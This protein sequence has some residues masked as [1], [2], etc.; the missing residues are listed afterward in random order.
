[1][2]SIVRIPKT[3]LASDADMPGVEIRKRAEPALKVR[4]R[5]P[6]RLGL[7]GGGTDVSPYS[8]T[9]GGCV[10]NA[11]ISMHAYC[12]IE[13]RADAQVGFDAKDLGKQWQSEAVPELAV[14]GELRLHKA[15]YNSVVAMFNDGEPLP[16]QVTT[17]SDAPPGSGLGSSSTMVV[18][19]LRAYQQLLQLPLG[20]YDLAQLAYRIERHDCALAGGKQ[21]QYAATFGGF[22]FI[23]FHSDD[24]VIVN[25]LRIR[26]EIVNELECHMM[27]F[28]TGLS[29]ESAKIIDDQSKIASTGNSD[30][31]TA[32]H[33][34]KEAAQAMKESLLKSDVRRMADILAESWQAK[35]HTSSSVSNPLVEYIYETAMGAG[36]LAAKL[37][38]AGGG[39]FMMLFV[40][41]TRKLEV[42]EALKPFGGSPYR[43]HFTKGGAQG[44][45]V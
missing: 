19:I 8:E 24:R 3:A 37:S 15:I 14:E 22:N 25:P 30:F 36:A 38:G 10:L 44:W 39:G 43:F 31:L 20:E 21:D 12:T 7:A 18:A 35:K 6:L 29:R 40:E 5:A 17:Y 26:D 42:T 2:A 34:V 9:Y 16:V 28:F 23:E 27:L 13:L 11:T 4:A 1:M 41:P 32:M 33:S 45:N